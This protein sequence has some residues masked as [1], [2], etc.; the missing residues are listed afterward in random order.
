MFKKMG[1]ERL[2]VLGFVVVMVLAVI[3]GSIWY[4][5]LNDID[6]NQEKLTSIAWEVADAAMEMKIAF[7]EKAFAHSAYIE[8]GD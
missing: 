5:I 3:V 6:G 2:L 4:Y 1:M 8:G 7:L